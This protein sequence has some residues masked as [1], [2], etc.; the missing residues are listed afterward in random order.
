MKAAN[1][2]TEDQLQIDLLNSAGVVR[3]AGNA[4]STATLNGSTAAGNAED[5]VVYDDLIGAWTAP[6]VMAGINTKIVRRS[7]AL[8]GHPWGREFRYRESVVTGRGAVGWLSGTTLTAGLGVFVA[9]MAMSPTRRFMRRFVLPK[10]GEGP[11]PAAQE[12]GYFTIEQIGV[13]G[14]GRRIRTRVTGD[15]DPGYGST[16]RMLAESAVCLACDH[17]DTPGGVLTPSAA[18]AQPLLARLRSNA[19]LSFEVVD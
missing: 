18:M 14:D 6:F 7:H 12:N 17:L 5:V 2:I 1:E 11:S 19:G 10:P 8:A 16:S 9:G 3:Y 4:T 15:R 13:T